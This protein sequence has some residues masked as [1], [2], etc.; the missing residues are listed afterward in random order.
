MKNNS[1]LCLTRLKYFPP[2]PNRLLYCSLSS[3]ITLSLLFF[4]VASHAQVSLL[5]GDLSWDRIN[6]YVANNH[7]S[8]VNISTDQASRL[9]NALF[10]DTRDPNEFRIS[11]IPN[12]TLYTRST[13]DFQKLPKNTLIIVYC[14][15]GIRSAKIAQELTQKGFT[16]VKNLQGSLFM[17]ANEGRPMQGTQPSKV[18]PYNS[19]WGALL[20]KK[21]HATDDL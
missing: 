1:L 13:P 12:A 2:L 21:I 18:H 6:Q 9:E 8:V 17:W 15:V 3:L 5:F 7:A 16:Q 11:H 19:R 10:V 4:S 14:S 20:E